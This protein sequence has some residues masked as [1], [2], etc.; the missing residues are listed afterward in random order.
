MRK[1]RRALRDNPGSP[2]FI[3]TVPAKGYRFIAAAYE[4]GAQPVRGSR[5]EG[6]SS[7]NTPESYVAYAAEIGE[8]RYLTVLV[9]NLVNPAG[10]TAPS[11]PEEWWERVADYRRAATDEIESYGGYVRPHHGAIIGYFGWPT[12]HDRDAERAVRAGLAIIERVAQFNERRARPKLSVRIGID[13][14]PVMVT[15]GADKSSDVI[16]DTPNIAA[17]AQEAA[18]PDMVLITAATHQLVSGLFVVGDCGAQALDDSG[19][20]I[21]TF[22]AIRPTGARGRL[23]AV[24]ATH[25]LTPFVGR[26]D[27]LRSLMNC[28]ERALQGEAQAALIIGEPGIGKSRLLWEFRHWITETPHT[29]AEAAAAPFFQNTPFYPVSDLLRQLMEA[30]RGEPS[31]TL[32][33]QLELTLEQA[34]LKP[35]EAVPLIAPILNL[36]VPEKYPPSTYAAERQRRRLLSALVELARGSALV[37]PLVIAVEDL[38]WADA[39]TLEFLELP[40]IS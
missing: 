8:R 35:A 14:G 28:W 36:P 34:G 37:Q 32:L 29:W 15:V 23:E 3:E 38:H 6:A 17:K 39:S 26:E 10:A 2:R 31:A 5:S 11:D 30:T 18:P 20:P 7:D 12:V 40:R 13:S 27:E 22:R 9:C 4:D 33:A 25:G 1:L 21:R 19:Q 24:A 16:G